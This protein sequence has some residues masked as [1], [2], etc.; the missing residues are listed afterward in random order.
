VH[1]AVRAPAAALTVEDVGHDF[2]GAIIPF[3]VEAEE[4][5]PCCSEVGG[6]VVVN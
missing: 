5:A 1:R 6:F 4:V 3:V 2:V